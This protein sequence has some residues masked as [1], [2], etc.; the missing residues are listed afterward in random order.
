MSLFRFVYIS[1]KPETSQVIRLLT[2]SLTALQGKDERGSEIVINKMNQGGKTCEELITF[3][4]E[5]I[6]IEE[7]YARDMLALSRKSC[8]LQEFGH[9]RDTFE[10]L[11]HQT[12][13][14]SQSHLKQAKTLKH[15]HL[16]QLE[17]YL[18]NYKGRKMPIESSLE[19]LKAA[20]KTMKD[21]VLK[22]KETY[23]RESSYL[24][25]LQA[26][27][28]IILGK[29]AE[30]TRDKQQK[31]Q[32]IV[33]D[34]REQYR[35]SAEQ[36]AE[37]N[38][39]WIDK[40]KI[41]S[42]ELEQYEM[43]RVS[44][45]VQS[46]WEYSNNISTSCVSDDLTC[47]NVRQALEKCDPAKEVAI[48]TKKFCTGSE[49]YSTPR[50][51]DYSNGEF[52]LENEDKDAVIEDA[53]KTIPGLSYIH[54]AAHSQQQHQNQDINQ[55]PTRLRSQH[56][57]VSHHTQ[58]TTVH[59]P[60]QQSAT[61]SPIKRQ[62][63]IIEH[64]FPTSTDIIN[65]RHLA[66]DEYHVVTRNIRKPPPSETGLTAISNPSSAGMNSD[67]HSHAGMN[68]EVSGYS[69]IPTTISEFSASI[70]EEHKIAKNW[71]SPMRRRSRSRNSVYLNKDKELP[72]VIVPVMKEPL[73]QSDR[74]TDLRYQSSRSSSY[75]LEV[76]KLTNS[77]NG[78]STFDPRRT[79]ARHQTSR[80]D[81]FQDR[82][83][84]LIANMKN[85]S[86]SM[87]SAK[88][89]DTTIRPKSMYDFNYSHNN[90]MHIQQPSN[91]MGSSIRSRTDKRSSFHAGLRSQ[92][93]SSLNLQSKISSNGLPIK[94]SDGRRVIRHA[95]AIYDFHASIDSELSF[96]KG[97]ILLVINKQE[98][99]WWE[100][101]RLGAGNGEFGL[102]PY[103]YVEEI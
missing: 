36:L 29:Q 10:L 57:S 84:D 45:I 44:F 85:F 40:W 52:D 78:L 96:N 62:S 48:F 60:S 47:E 86:S 34:L 3:Y 73:S 63:Q 43:E 83:S 15:E 91:D 82:D 39:T 35:T 42:A 23:K 97:D 67:E 92:S 89:N 68:S 66:A 93:R 101:E 95:K 72:P 71:N 26:N 24:K 12:K 13:E 58:S 88:S 77:L 32:R 49:I 56:T 20:K 61:Q 28:G 37:L 53:R 65:D 7:N 102:V 41:S 69:S 99:N 22:I 5:R 11:K 76:E 51:V 25:T 70:D 19:A 55:S 17:T 50:F 94:T 64:T 103:N 6:R 46:L 100:C 38:K 8:G 80:S 81:D 9:M 30:K 98:D 27:D 21:K 2:L 31:Q 14:V 59:R 87:M 90:N 1:Y 18:S 4:K 79:N 33:E 75:N 54:T 74:A 16:T